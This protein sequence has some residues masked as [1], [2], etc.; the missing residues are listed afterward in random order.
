MVRSKGLNMT[1]DE[2]KAAWEKVRALWGG[3]G[4]S[5]TGDTSRFNADMLFKMLANFSAAA[6][7]EAI[8]AHVRDIGTKKGDAFG[9]VFN[10]IAELA[11][12]AHWRKQQADPLKEI[13]VEWVSRL[14]R[15]MQVEREVRYYR[16]MAQDRQNSKIER[17]RYDS[18]A[19]I[20]EQQLAKWQGPM[21]PLEESQ[22]DR[23][24]E[25]RRRAEAELRGDAP[26]EAVADR[27]RS[28][29]TDMRNFRF[30]EVPNG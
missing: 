30:K 2:F 12:D 5:M 8:E 3:W 16:L 14:P 15:P 7:D 24:N 27:V 29:P 18:M 9:P 23:A 10:R 22:L 6:V 17:D 11:K 28:I 20:G 25:W 1:R 21:T 4:R 19:M 26:D 13:F